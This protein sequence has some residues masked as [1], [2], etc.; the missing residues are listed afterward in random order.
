MKKKLNLRE[1][2]KFYDYKVPT[3]KTHA[4]AINAVLGEDLAVALL[5]HHLKGVGL[6]VI[7][8]DGVCAQGT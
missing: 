6:E 7:A 2:L 1:L 3:S 4:S 5:V 8:L